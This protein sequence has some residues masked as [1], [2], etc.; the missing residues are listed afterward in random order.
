METKR[1]SYPTTKRMIGCK[2]VDKVKYLVGV[3]VTQYEV[4]LVGN[5]HH[6]LG[7]RS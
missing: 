7:T 1:R 2:W 4:M 3:I 6:T 5:K